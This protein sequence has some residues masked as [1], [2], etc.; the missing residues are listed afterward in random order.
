LA[1]NLFGFLLM[2]R[3]KSLART[4]G[5]RV[6]ES[7]FLLVALAGGAAGVFLGVRAFRHKTRHLKFTVAVP[8]ILLAQLLLAVWLWL[9]G[10][11]LF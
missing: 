6:S 10:I 7:S 2:G 1:I 3:D 5:W 9:K 8:V 4:G 11:K